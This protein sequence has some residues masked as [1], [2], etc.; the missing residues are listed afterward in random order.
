MAKFKK[1]PQVFLFRKLIEYW[2]NT[3]RNF[4]D[5][6][7]DT[8]FF[9]VVQ[10]CFDHDKAVEL[11]ELAYTPDE[12][13]EMRNVKTRRWRLN[14]GDFLGE[15]F[16]VL[17]NFARLRRK[18]RIVLDSICDYMLKENKERGKD[19]L[20]KRIEELSKALKLSALETEILTLAYIRSET[21]FVW[22]Q[23]VDTR[24]KPL[25]YAMALDCSHSEVL[26]AM[27][28]KGTLRKF[29]LLD[30]DFE[31]SSRTIGGFMD[32]S[33]DSAFDRRFYRKSEGE[34]VLPWDYYGELSA[35]DGEILKSMIG[36]MQGRCNVLLYGAPGTGK[37]S[38][39]RSLAK[40]L[41]RTAYEIAQGDEDG[42]NM[43]VEARLIGIRACNE[44]EDSKNSLIIVDEADELLR[45]RAPD[46]ISSGF[47][48]R[49]GRSVEKGVTNA[50]LD[51]MKIPAVW[52]SNAPP[53]VMDES[54]RRRFDYSICFER[55]NNAQRVA[56]WKN[57]VDRFNISNLVAE[58][59]IE[60]Y[61]AKYE[62]SAGGISMVL[63]N[64]K[65]MN[66]EAEMTDEIIATL[67]KPHCRLMGISDANSF[68]PASDYALTG[69]NIKGKVSL[70]RVVKAAGNYLDASYSA[71][72]TDRPRMN[73]LMY[74][75]PGT[76]KTE[77]VKY[78]GKALDRKVLVM[79]GSDILGMYVGESE[80]NIARVFRQAEAEKAILFFDEIDG[81]LQSR[82]NAHARWE[83]SQ[84][85]E[86]LQQMENFNGVM[87]AATNFSKN[88][89]PAVMR[90]FT[91]KLEFGY[92]DDDGV[93][94]FFEK[95]FKTE[96][97]D[98]E[99]AELKTLKNLAPGDFR[100]VRQ[101]MFYL[102]DEITNSDRI[103]ALK[104]ECLHK[105]DVPKIAAIGFGV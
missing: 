8:G 100:T 63:G 26:A 9:N 94:I 13:E 47:G 12:L 78:L 40:E 85:N 42:E 80:K 55:L 102:G 29:H 70:D 66:P 90:R 77:F 81:L 95:M 82:E 11:I 53:E 73:I 39:A 54:V 31:F 4:D 86:L 76:G 98:E 19:F 41:A 44:Q 21:C 32:G 60:E 43:K 57:L 103:A 75:P 30:C 50:I 105:K 87:V 92:L 68:L 16:F 93:K 88:L 64:V 28:P 5:E 89:D 18:C 37:T 49:G 15:V 67:M 97:S 24:D 61:A 1:V 20:E 7:W 14:L 6:C 65:R 23:R 56:I 69:L 27:S 59:K 3:V 71:G 25:Y 22:P 74:G 45:G 2:R 33:L 35:V 101:E 58:S 72:A 51:E 17:W 38:F 52:I 62:T 91:F 34:D 36:A 84:V 104:E 48:G 83:V 10:N 99:F 79:K 96:L 46:R